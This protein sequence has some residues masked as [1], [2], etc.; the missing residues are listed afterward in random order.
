MAGNYPI[1]AILRDIWRTELRQN[2]IIA[3]ELCRKSCQYLRQDDEPNRRA[4]RLHD[5]Q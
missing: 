3:V 4:D 5:C 2:Q 1:Y